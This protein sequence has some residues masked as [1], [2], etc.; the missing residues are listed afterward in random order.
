[1]SQENVPRH[2]VFAFSLQVDAN[3]STKGVLGDTPSYACAVC[4]FAYRCQ[5][6]L[7][8]RW[9]ILFAHFITVR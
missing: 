5:T 4:T 2:H 3:H 7:V 6:G 8:S 1:M 9:L